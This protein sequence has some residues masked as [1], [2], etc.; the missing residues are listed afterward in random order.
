[1]SVGRQEPLR[2]RL[3][4]LAAVRVRSGYRQLHTLLHREG[5]LVNQKRVCRL[6]ID[7]GLDLI[8][9]TVQK[10]STS[11]GRWLIT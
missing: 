6:Y 4:E 2:A 10:A 1:M 11:P 8:R 7:E 3:R 9:G 5:W